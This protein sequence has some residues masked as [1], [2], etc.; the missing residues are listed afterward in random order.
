MV[1]GNPQAGVK[2]RFLHTEVASAHIDAVLEQG[3]L[4]PQGLRNPLVTAVSYLES[5]ER[6]GC[7]T[8]AS[9]GRMSCKVPYEKIEVSNT[10][11]ASRS[12]IDRANVN[13][14]HTDHA[15]VAKPRTPRA[16]T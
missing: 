16:V 9:P 8:P 13:C 5:A 4:C 14:S 1:G 15:S 6:T 12:S 7:T 11:V 10:S 2:R 3:F